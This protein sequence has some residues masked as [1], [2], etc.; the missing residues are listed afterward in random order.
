MNT[1]EKYAAQKRWHKN[2]RDKAKA[3]DRMKPALET[4]DTRLE[5]NTKP[6]AMEIRAIARKGLGLD[7]A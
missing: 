7:D 2:L 3:H 5:G 4:I 6:L 1:N